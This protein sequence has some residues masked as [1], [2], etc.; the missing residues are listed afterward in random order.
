MKI[1]LYLVIM[2]GVVLSLFLI[3]G[4]L[5]ALRKRVRPACA[6]LQALFRARRFVLL[7][8]QS[9]AIAAFFLIQPVIIA[10]AVALIMDGLNPGF[11]SEVI[12][13]IRAVL[14]HPPHCVLWSRECRATG[15]PVLNSRDAGRILT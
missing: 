9:S 1:E 3:V 11:S 4:E 8:L 13:Q 10:V 15:N 6:R 12:N 14:L 7:A 5:A 2:A